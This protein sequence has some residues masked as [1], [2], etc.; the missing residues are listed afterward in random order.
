M[1]KKYWHVALSN[2]LYLFA[3]LVMIHTRY[4]K[5]VTIYMFTMLAIQ[6]LLLV[7]VL[8]VR[9]NRRKVQQTML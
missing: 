6:A 7:A 1:I 8:I 2:L 5:Y 9:R 3:P 4:G